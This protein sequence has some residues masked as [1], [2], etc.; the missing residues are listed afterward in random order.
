MLLHRL[1]AALKAAADPAKAPQMTAYM[2]NIQP[3]H[4]V[5]APVQRQV[6][7]EVFKDV[8]F[9][10][11]A[12][13][14]TTVLHIWRNAKFREERYAVMALCHGGRVAAFQTMEAL[15]VYEELIV[16][17][18]W[19]DVVDHIASNFIGGLLKKHPKP[20]THKMLLWSKSDDMWKRR[21]SILCQLKFNENTDL[22]L[23]YACI[24]PSIESKEFFLRKAIGWALRQ[25]AK[26]D[27]NEIR[28]YVRANETRL[29]G[30][31]KREA[32][33]NL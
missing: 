9:A 19:W 30:L 33:K 22:D 3:Y 12:A 7:R 5:T 32:L 28:R 11:A 6:F 14:R 13:W 23:L 24:E 8:T 1:R 31:S 20:M 17:G 15:P 16:T 27:P 18:A 4:G 2:K 29:S 21:T 10:D 26:S 25:H